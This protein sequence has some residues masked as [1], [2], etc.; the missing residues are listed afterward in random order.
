[1]ANILLAPDKFKGSLSARGVAEAL[2][3]GLQTPFPTAS[4]TIHPMADGGDGSLAILREHLALEE[5]TVDTV[6]PL[7]RPLQTSYLCDDSSAF[8]EVASASGIVLLKQEELNPSLTSTSGTG[9]MIA[10]AIATGKCKIYL[11]LGGSATNDLG[12][13]IAHALG[14]RLLDGSSQELVPQ[15][16]NLSL[17]HTIVPPPTLPDIEFTLLCDVNNP[18]YGPNGAAHVYA[19]QKGADDQMIEQLDQGLQ[20]A[21]QLLEHFSGNAITQLPGAGAAGG[22]SAGLLALFPTTM[23]PG[24]QMMSELTNLET[25]VAQADIVI[26]GEGKLDSQSLQ[27]KVVDGLLQLCKQYNK[28][29]YLAVGHSEL[30]EAAWRAAGIENVLPITAFAKDLADAL[31]RPGYYLEIIGQQLLTRVDRV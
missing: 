28:P 23:R 27:G 8:I 1:M 6:D 22:I 30:H 16:K 21:G 7:G 29:L 12:L 3:I 26:S 20:H 5:V 4:F 17:I 11:F 24:F 18:L 10:H 2:I 25:Q 13:G 14:Y 9:K 31:A 19:R 15:G